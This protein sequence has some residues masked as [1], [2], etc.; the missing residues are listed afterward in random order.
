MVICRPPRSIRRRG[1]HT[2]SIVTVS[3][4]MS[5][6][7]IVRIR[8]NFLS[9][10][11][12]SGCANTRPK[13]SIRYF[14]LALIFFRTVVSPIRGWS[15]IFP[16]L[17]RLT[18]RC[19]SEGRRTRGKRAVASRL[20][21]RSNTRLGTRV[22]KRASCLSL[23]AGTPTSVKPSAQRWLIWLVPLAISTGPASCPCRTN[24]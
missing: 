16:L 4:K 3:V 8:P 11:H 7:A 13:R 21:T 18:A 12:L 15:R 23:T 1:M 20:T 6:A 17:C 19:V 9:H 2:F 10:C 14:G 24:F 22:G 5:T